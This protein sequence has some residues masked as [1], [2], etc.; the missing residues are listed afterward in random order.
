MRGLQDFCML[1]GPVP[2]LPSWALGTWWGCP[3][4]SKAEAEDIVSG[5]STSGVKLSAVSVKLSLHNPER[6]QQELENLKSTISEL[7]AHGLL[8]SIMYLLIHKA[9]NAE[10]D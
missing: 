5:F 1:A 9:Y 4:R 2:L 10:L 8:F 7:K 6:L 3:I